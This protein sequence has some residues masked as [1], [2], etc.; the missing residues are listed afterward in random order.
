[1]LHSPA[2]CVPKAS[3]DIFTCS[4]TGGVKRER[5]PHSLSGTFYPCLTRFSKGRSVVVTSPASE[6][7]MVPT[8]VSHS[9][10][11][12]ECKRGYR[13]GC[14]CPG[15]HR[16]T[17]SLGM[18]SQGGIARGGRTSRAHLLKG[19]RFTGCHLPMHSFQCSF[20]CLFLRTC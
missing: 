5:T 10:R 18:Q 12:H 8:P 4:P 15:T 1:M 20:D 14:A 9:S 2:V 11:S 6:T 17:G 3:P 16:D 7:G 13:E 19:N